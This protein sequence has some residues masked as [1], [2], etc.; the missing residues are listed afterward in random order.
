M[1]VQ[2]HTTSSARLQ[3]V[4]PRAALVAVLTLY[5]S[6]GVLLAAVK[7]PWE[8]PDEVDHVRNV[9]TLASGRLYR[10]R[11]EEG[12]ESYQPP[13]YYS[14]LAGWQQVWGVE[15]KKPATVA[16]VECAQAVYAGRTS[17]CS[18]Y[19]HG[20]PADGDDQRRVTLL[21]LPGVLLGAIVILLTA[22]V[23]RRLTSDPWTPV[24]GAAI[25]ASVP[26]FVAAS[27]SV[28]NDNLATLLGAVA[29]L[30]AVVALARRESGNDRQWPLAVALGLVLGAFV[31]TKFTGLLLVPALV[32]VLWL[33]AGSPRQRSQL[34][35]AF[36]AVALAVSGWWLIRNTSLYGDPL[37]ATASE[38]H[39]RTVLPWAFADEPLLERTFVTHPQTLWE[40][41]WYRSQQF[42]WSWW[43]YLP[44]WLLAAGGVVALVRDR[45]GWTPHPFFGRAVVVLA[46]LA[47]G[48]FA[49]IWTVGGAAAT[50]GGGQ[51]R[52]T[53][54]GLPAFACLIALGFERLRAPLPA[55]FL[56]PVLGFLGTLVAIRHD[57]L[58]IYL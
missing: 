52:Y 37:A 23:A 8:A 22:A 21:R 40:E 31:L 39:L 11:P 56:L 27:A 28:S 6:L 18:I 7:P 19:D 58:D 20:T 50:A 16:S 3:R 36:G 4:T 57:V 26:S 1:S 53:F 48:G 12:V 45:R 55:R 43:A 46:L 44:F 15:A 34:I 24:V 5:V 49:T 51:G 2:S 10:M 13:L 42:K 32:T 54:I 38:D 9:E 33:S 47:I 17:R 30:L 14:L 29:T 41:F 25:V 35:L